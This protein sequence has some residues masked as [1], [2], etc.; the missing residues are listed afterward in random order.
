MTDHLWEITIKHGKLI[1]YSID[2]LNYTKN[3][4][5]GLLTIHYIRLVHVSITQRI[6]GRIYWQFIIRLVHVFITWS[7]TGKFYWQSCNP[8]KAGMCVHHPYKA[9]TCVH[10]ELLAHVHHIGDVKALHG[11]LIIWM[12][13]KNG[14]DK[15]RNLPE[16]EGSR[17]TW[18]KIGHM[19]FY[20][21]G[22]HIN[23]NEVP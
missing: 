6:T 2:N 10:E 16:Q 20:M 1:N 17:N 21:H 15:G 5:N 4:Q 7:T 8:Y 19:L 3:S 12:D 14:L 23:L 13:R 11:C 9:G 18:V 22:V